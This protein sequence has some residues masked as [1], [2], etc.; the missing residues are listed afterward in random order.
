MSAFRTLAGAALLLGLLGLTYSQASHS[1]S[2]SRSRDSEDRGN[3]VSATTHALEHLE[4]RPWSRDAALIAARSLSR[5][6]F[7][8]QA[9]PYYQRVGELSYEDRHYRAYGLVRANLRERAIRAYEDILAQYPDDVTALQ[10]ITGVMMTQSRWDD[11]RSMAR[12]LI[13]LADGPTTL[14]VPVTTGDNWTLETVEDRLPPVIG[15]TLDGVVNHN[16]QES[17]AAVSA[18]ETVLELD[19]DLNSMPLPRALFWSHLAEDLLREGRPDDAL[20]HLSLA[21][22]D[23]TDPDLLDQMG[24]AHLQKSNLDE[25][26]QCWRSALGWAPD[27]FGSLLNLGK[28]DLQRGRAEEAIRSLRLALQAQPE[29]YEVHYSLGLAYRRIDREDLAHRHQ[30]KAEQIRTG[31]SP[32]SGDS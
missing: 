4:R 29:S 17:T 28:L 32:R 7:A 8:E 12:R 6:D 3:Y 1:P 21:L 26:E 30:E 20:R 31:D 10:M 22:E 14:L 18:F 11:V 9:E 25:A 23:G 15:W 5:L 27:H 16:R 2:L 13:D 19:P 24:R